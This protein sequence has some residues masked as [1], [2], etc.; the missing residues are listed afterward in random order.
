M[1]YFHILPLA[2]LI[3]SA[4]SRQPDKQLSDVEEE[5][6][7]TEF[8]YKQ[9]IPEGGI[10]DENHGAQVWFGLTSLSGVDDFIANGVAQTFVFEDG[11][12][13]HGLQLNIERAQDGYFYE[14]WLVNPSNGDVLST[15]HLRSLFGDVRHALQFQ[16]DDNLTGYTKVIVTLEPDD[17]DPS[18]AE[19]A[20]E[21]TL[22]EI[23]R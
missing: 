2:L 5:D 16:S 6:L 19:H 15:G 1:K 17:G 21:G 11:A 22:K 13:Q 23:Q 10:V 7:Q 20:A 4:C 8:E 3:L 14:G 9:T 12:S 18:P